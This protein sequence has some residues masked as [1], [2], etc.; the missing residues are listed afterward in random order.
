MM[1]INFDL[2]HDTDQGL[3]LVKKALVRAIKLVDAELEC[4]ATVVT[5]VAY[6]ALGVDSAEG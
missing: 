6:Q 2:E 1:R 4:R 5:P 3:F